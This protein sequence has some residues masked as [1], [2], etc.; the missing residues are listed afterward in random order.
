MHHHLLGFQQLLEAA[1]WQDAGQL[2]IGR[3][4]EGFVAGVELHGY[5]EVNGQRN[6]VV[7]VLQQ[8]DGEEVESIQDIAVHMARHG[9]AVERYEGEMLT[10]WRLD[11]GDHMKELQ[12]DQMSYLENQEDRNQDHGGK[13][14]LWT[15]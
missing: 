10:D 7:V 8:V 4:H 2:L 13:T 9:E 12:R 3:K 14:Q 6:M 5:S 1:G 15:E 11:I